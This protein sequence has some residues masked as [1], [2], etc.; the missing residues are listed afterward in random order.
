MYYVPFDIR[1]ILEVRTEL[2]QL[3]TSVE[4]LMYIACYEWHIMVVGGTCPSERPI[5]SED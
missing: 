3:K 2:P 5:R 1:W 4:L